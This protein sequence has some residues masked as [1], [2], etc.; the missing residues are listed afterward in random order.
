LENKEDAIGKWCQLLEQGIYVNLV[1]PPASPDG[2]SLL[3]CSISADHRPEQVDR[4][5]DA[6]SRLV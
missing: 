6:F 2:G 3:R 1:L 4:I 5:M